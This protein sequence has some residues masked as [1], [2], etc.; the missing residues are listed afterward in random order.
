VLDKIG[1]DGRLVKTVDDFV[2]DDENA[3][4]FVVVLCESVRVWRKDIVDNLKLVV[5]VFDSLYILQKFS[6]DRQ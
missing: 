5:D 6:G 1:L 4:P 2:G 3:A